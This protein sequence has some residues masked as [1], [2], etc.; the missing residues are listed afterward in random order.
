MPLVLVFN[1]PYCRDILGVAVLM[2]VTVAA[3]G[4]YNL[5]TLVK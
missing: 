3:D 5:D 4:N 1:K 2:L